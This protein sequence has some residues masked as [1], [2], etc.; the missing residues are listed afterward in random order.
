MIK[1]SLLLQLK[2]WLHL[3]LENKWLKLLSIVLAV[4]LFIFSRQPSADV[5]LNGVPVEFH[6][7]PPGM[8]IVTDD[9]PMVTVRLHGPRNVVTGLT[10]NQIWVTANLTNKEPGARIAHLQPNNVRRPDHVEVLQISP[11]S[12]RLHL[13]RTASRSV[14]V[15]AKM[16]NR[17]IPGLEIYDIQI[18]PPVIDIEGPESEVN[19]V[20]R[21]NTETVN[22]AG[23]TG[24][25]ETFVDV[26]TSERIRVKTQDSIKLYIEIGEIREHRLITGI[27]VTN[28]SARGTMTVSGRPI[29]LGQTSIEIF[30]PR[31]LVRSLTAADVRATVNLSGSPKSGQQSLPAIALP[32]QYRSQIRIQ[33]VMPVKSYRKGR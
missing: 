3:Q 21:L 29:A 5:R 23:R 8:E 24:P 32:D 26:E 17:L 18:I 16:D 9:S 2:E 13:E 20:E 12:L 4:L 25:F 1:L 27:N 14:R 33:K 7:V 28:D 15:D 19:K 6:G 10:S 22:L 31:S 11:P 30:G